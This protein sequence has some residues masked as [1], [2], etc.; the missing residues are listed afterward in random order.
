V[1]M[2]TAILIAVFL[3][4][5]S[6]LFPLS[7]DQ[8]GQ[9][10]L[11]AAKQQSNLFQQDSD[12]FQLEV[13]F[14]VQIQVPTQGHL[15][16]KWEADNRWWRRIVAGNFEQIDM[17][18][19]DR[20]YTT[21]NAPFTPLRIL[22]LMSLLHFA[23]SEGLV[24]K[25][26]KKRIVQGVA[27]TCFE[28]K[29][30]SSTRGEPT[31]QDCVNST[32]HELL[33]DEWEVAADEQRRQQYA[34]YFDFRALRYPRTLELFVNG[35]KEITAHVAGLTAANLDPALLVPRAGAIERRQ[36]ADMKRPLP[37]KTPDPSYPRSAAQN[38]MMGDTTV[39][40]TVLADGSVTDIQLLGR[41]TQSM[42]DA[43]LQTLRTWKFKP[44]MCGTEPVVTDIEVVV[45][46]RLD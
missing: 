44:A 35:S 30:E 39:A 2:K 15:T 46:F 43:T 11:I 19:G 29:R 7:D 9:Q 16:F 4:S 42:D 31:H 33:S 26:E 17:R 41:A 28:V 20:L 22:E 24:V 27:M 45:S 3:F 32:T 34:E 10:L 38:G 21:R 8:A 13:E 37:V 12:P 40:M 5:P 23:H 6:Q 14:V 18:N 36:C 1:S 25:K